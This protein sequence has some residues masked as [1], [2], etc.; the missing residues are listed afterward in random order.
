MTQIIPK[1]R[2]VDCRQYLIKF[3]LRK[4]RQGF[5]PYVVDAR[6]QLWPTCEATIAALGLRSGQTVTAATLAEILQRDSV[7]S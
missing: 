3:A 6:G 2:P 1:D 7:T 4:M 5:I